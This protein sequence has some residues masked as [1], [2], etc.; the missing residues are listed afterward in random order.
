[1]RTLVL[2]CSLAVGLTL[3]AC[4]KKSSEGEPCYSSTSNT[5]DCEEGLSCAMCEG[6]QICVQVQGSGNG[7]SLRVPGR[8]CE[9]L[10]N[11]REK[12][13]IK[14]GLNNDDF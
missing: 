4:D 12:G 7:G 3:G 11:M 13:E 2:L 8:V 14:R 6:Q 5:T 1:M 10:T 9:R